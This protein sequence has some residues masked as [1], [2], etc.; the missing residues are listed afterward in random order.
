MAGHFFF[1]SQ[2]ENTQTNQSDLGT[3]FGQYYP[4]SDWIILKMALVK[5][6]FT[7]KG[8]MAYRTFPG[9]LLYF[10]NEQERSFKRQEGKDIFFCQKFDFK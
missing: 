8:K 1:D 2:K 5:V 7:I 10:V 4:G 9:H 3:A 6:K